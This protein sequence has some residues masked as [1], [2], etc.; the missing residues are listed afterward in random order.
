MNIQ[1]KVGIT[2]IVVTHD[3]EEAMTLSSRIAVMDRGQ[4]YQ[5]GRPIEIYEFPNCR[6]TAGFVG[7]MN[8]FEGVVQTLSDDGILHV[9]GK[10][11]GDFRVVYAGA[12]LSE[13]ASV[14]VALRPE[15]I[16]LSLSP[17]SATDNMLAGKVKDL[18]YFGGTTCYRIDTGK[19]ELVSVNVT[20]AARALALRADWNEKVFL[21]WDPAAAVVLTE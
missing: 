9:S 20:N 7:T 16:S 1:D 8:M 15:K 13:G 18:G 2:F 12:P 4:V 11:G 14:W 5:V 17:V 21:T 10:N 3:Q 6:F 19:G